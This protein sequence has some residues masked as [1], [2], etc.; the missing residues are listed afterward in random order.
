M[1]WV[2]L[3]EL[4]GLLIVV[5]VLVAIP[6]AIVMNVVKSKRVK[7]EREEEKMKQA[8]RHREREQSGGV[9]GIPRTAEELAAVLGD[10]ESTAEATSKVGEARIKAHE[11]I[12]KAEIQADKIIR[13]AER[14]ARDILDSAKKEKELGV[15]GEI[16]AQ[17]LEPRQTGESKY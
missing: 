3:G 15:Q 6:A 5:F 10:E 12:E 7:K 14:A 13:Q 11:I 17:E 4:T 1:T 2:K 16:K 9:R 8:H